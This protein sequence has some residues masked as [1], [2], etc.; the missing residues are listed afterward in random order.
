MVND[1]VYEGDFQEDDQVIVNWILQGLGS[2]IFLVGV[3][4]YM[5]FSCQWGVGNVCVLGVDVFQIGIL[6]WLISD[7]VI[8]MLVG[9]VLVFKID[10]Q[11][12]VGVGSLVR[13]NV[14]FLY[15][16]LGWG[17][18][19]VWRFVCDLFVGGFC[20]CCLGL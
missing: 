6:D 4:D 12:L 16:L 20:L 8:V 19:R 15:C 3:V 11:W 1:S 17:L 5:D 13:V 2:K 7:I 18:L 14:Q 9:Q 10:V